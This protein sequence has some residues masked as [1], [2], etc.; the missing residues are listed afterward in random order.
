MIS[1]DDYLAFWSIPP[2]TPEAEAAWNDKVA[3]ENGE[4]TLYAPLVFVQRD[5]CYDS[6][7]DGRHI[8]NKHARIE[9]LARSGCIEYDPE[10]KKDSQRRIKQSDDALDKSVGEYVHEQFNKMPTAKRERLAN[11]LLAGT[12]AEI[13][14]LTAGE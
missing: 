3:F 12:T 7:I 5:I 1:K 10:M 4:R 8:T 6:P 14:R 9:D 2:G 11:E 13:V